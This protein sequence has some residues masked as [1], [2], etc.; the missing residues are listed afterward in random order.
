MLFSRTVLDYWTVVS[1]LNIFYCLLIHDPLICLNAS[2]ASSTNETVTLF[3][4]FLHFDRLL[5]SA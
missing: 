3:L 2:H 1:A 5:I 4:H